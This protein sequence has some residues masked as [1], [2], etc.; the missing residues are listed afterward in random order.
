MRFHL[1]PSALLL[2]AACAIRPSP[3]HVVGTQRE[4]AVLTGEWSGE[5]SSAETGRSGSISFS[6]KAGTDTAFGDVVMVPRSMAPSTSDPRSVTAM[7]STPRVL[8][9]A[10]VRVATN[11]VSGTLAP[12]PSPDCG[13]MLSTVFHG[14]ISG[15]R[16]EGTFTSAHSDQMAPQ[17]KGTWWVTRVVSAPPP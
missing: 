10:F 11:V 8:S 4:M 9:I 2:V 6:L 1:A 17:Q 13:C 16:I 12:Y 15:N 14:S 5:Y 7:P 3:V